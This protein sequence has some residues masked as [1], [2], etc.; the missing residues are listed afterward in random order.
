M[1]LRFNRNTKLFLASTLLYGFSFSVWQL[2]FNL[3]ILSLGFNS[4]MLGLIL[5]ATPLAALILGL[6]LGLLSDRIGRR[7]SMI[8]GLVIG[9]AGM[10]LEIHLR[11]PWLIFLFGLVQGVG[12]ILYRIAQSPFIMSASVP[13]NQAMIFSLN[14]GLM[15]VASTIGNLVAGQMPSLLERWLGLAQGTSAAY[16]WVITA[17]ILFAATSLIPILMIREERLKN[18]TPARQIPL[19]EM[20]RKI[21][22]QPIARRLGLIN[23]LIGLGAAI[24]IPYLNVFLRTKFDVSDNLL[25]LIFSLSSLL[26]F[27]GTVISPWTVRVTHSRIIP[28]VAT[29][30]ASLV[31]LFTLG[32][33]PILW[34]AV[35]S[36]FL[37][38]VLM[39]SSSPLVD[40]FAM[41][42]SSPDEQGTIASVRM[43]SWQAGQTI[44]LF[45][46]GLVQTRFGFSPLFIATGLLYGLASTLTWFY[47]RPLEKERQNVLTV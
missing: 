42:I 30:G 15:T 26:V 18:D 43:T 8:L 19:K 10:L 12:F 39:Q 34:I 9:F 31:F 47:F 35:I 36:L 23:G 46:S 21:I 29:Q 5:S 22:R 7:T 20:L 16:Q 13:E 41:L 38:N 17:G 4:D 33:S 32:F 44:G 25:G 1:R 2:F 6:P 27:L 28:T 11:S 24:L 3:Y 37:R 40:N 45:I 14:F